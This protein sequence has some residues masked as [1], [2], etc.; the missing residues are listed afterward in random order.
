MEIFY[1]FGNALF[2]SNGSY[3]SHSILIR[4]LLICKICR[5]WDELGCN[6]ACPIHFTEEE[7][8][9]HYKD[10]EGWNERADF[11]DSIAGFVSRDGWTA[12]ET[13]D[14][15]LDMFAELR[16]EGLKNLDGKEREDFEAQTK[17]AQRRSSP[18]QGDI[19]IQ[20]DTINGRPSP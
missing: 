12:N 8:Q 19:K 20:P 14:Q 7:L 4:K 5:H 3:D 13:H 15:A 9:A 11:W 1:L 10:G 16:E 6:I 18:L 17:W 2:E